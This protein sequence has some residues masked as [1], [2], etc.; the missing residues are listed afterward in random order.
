[1]SI[2]STGGKP[3]RR[4]GRRRCS[5]SRH[6][7]ASKRSCSTMVPAKASWMWTRTMA[8][9]WV[10]DMPGHRFGSPGGGGAGRRVEN[11]RVSAIIA[12]ES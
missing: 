1:M 7:R 3:P 9:T 6:Q 5:C 8:P 4:A 11:S 10:S 12:A 2:T